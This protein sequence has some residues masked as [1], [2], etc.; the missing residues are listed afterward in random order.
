M[1]T[2]YVYSIDP[3]YLQTLDI[4]LA[5][6]RDFNEQIPSDSSAV[7]VNEAL[8]ADMGWDD[9]LS[10]H[11]NWRNDSL[12]EG[13]RV[14][15]VAK[16]YHFRSLEMEIEPLMLTLG[17]ENMWIVMVRL[18]PGNLTA[19]V[20]KVQTIWK[21]LYRDKPFNYRFLDEDLAR[22]YQDYQRWMKIMGLSTLFAI[23]ISN[24]GLFGLSGI[25]TLNRTKEIGI[26]KV[27]G[28]R[29]STIFFLLNKRY[30]ALALIA[31]A[32]A[33]PLSWY[34]MHQWMANFQ[35]SID[36][37]WRIFALSMLG[38]LFI[39]LITV[40]YHATKIALINPT[41]TLKYE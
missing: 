31:F 17:K 26:R 21:E 29:L 4:S 36:I 40:S 8:V 38:G 1:K 9:P 41:E 23:L 12:S 30:V 34:V 6:G 32:M 39:A 37:S 7:I 35:Y 22:Q 25:N 20:E 13:Y 27:F 33:I 5:Q 19:S 24:L 11:L 28:A 14:I 16:D 15:G 18:Q 2:T 10:E 3:Y